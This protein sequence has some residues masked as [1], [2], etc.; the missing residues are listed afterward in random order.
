MKSPRRLSTLCSFAL[1]CS[2]LLAPTGVGARAATKVPSV[3]VLLSSWKAWTNS[4]S[5]NLHSYQLDGKFDGV[6]DVSISDTPPVSSRSS[7]TFR[8]IVDGSQYLWHVELGGTKTIAVNR[9]GFAVLHCAPGKPSNHCD[10]YEDNQ[11]TANLTDTLDSFPSHVLPFNFPVF[12]VS[13]QTIYGGV[14]YS[15]TLFN[16]PLG[17]THE[18]LSPNLQ[19]FFANNARHLLVDTVTTSGA[20]NGARIRL[21][22]PAS[23]A[24]IDDRAP[25]Q[26][27]F[28]KIDGK[29]IPEEFIDYDHDTV[30]LSHFVN[31]DGALLP[32]D[33]AVNSG[34]VAHIRLRF[35]HVGEAFPASA[36]TIDF[37]PGTN[38][39]SSDDVYRTNVP[40][41][42]AAFLIV[43]VMITLALLVARK[44]KL[45]VK[46]SESKQHNGLKR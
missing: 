33:I 36:F 24:R 46:R 35:S 42:R 3:Q 17:N 37:P 32:A 7:G 6:Q 11:D 26:V 31:F 40:P 14:I 28:A 1:L 10:G 27:L 2:T 29:L 19:A 22:L 41:Y 44:Y 5:T 25:T 38:R 4:V 45:A 39:T 43:M 34:G 20:K 18:G 8:S 16:G 13:P 9:T 21:S 12:C 30:T 15:G 23:A